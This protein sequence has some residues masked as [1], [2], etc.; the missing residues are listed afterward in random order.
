LTEGCKKEP[1]SATSAKGAVVAGRAGR[2][3]EIP[4]SAGVK[5][6]RE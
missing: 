2:S 6:K 5:E 1:P 3:E 4:T